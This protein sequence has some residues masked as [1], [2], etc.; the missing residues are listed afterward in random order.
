MGGARAARA[1]RSLARARVSVAGY[2]LEGEGVRVWVTRL[3]LLLAGLD[4]PPTTI[5]VTIT[6]GRTRQHTFNTIKNC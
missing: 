2:T 1:T 5:G 6:Q 4:H 3:R